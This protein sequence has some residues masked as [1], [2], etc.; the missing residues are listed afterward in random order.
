[1]ENELVDWINDGQD[2]EAPFTMEVVQ[3]RARQLA[4]ERNNTGFEASSGW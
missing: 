4:E 1:M 3:T 2:R